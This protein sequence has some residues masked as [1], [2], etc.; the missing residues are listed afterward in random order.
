MPLLQTVKQNS[1]AMTSGSSP[2]AAQTG[3][4][5]TGGDQTQQT[6]QL[7][8]VAQTGKDL[9]PGIGGQAKLS[10]LGERLANVNTLMSASALQ[11]AG[12]MQSEAQQQQ[13][14]AQQQQTQGQMRQLSQEHLDQVES[15]NNQLSGIMQNKADEIQRMVLSDDKSKV[16]QV[17]LML[18]L[19]NDKYMDQ[20]SAAATRARL[21]NQASFQ[22]A[23]N[24]SVFAQETQL[25]GSSLEF[26]NYLQADRRAATD[27][28]ANMDIDFALQ[29]A[30]ADN[31]AAAAT[32]MWS[33]VGGIATGIGELAN[34]KSKPKP[35]D[36]P[37][38][39]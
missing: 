2:L 27:Q 10:A 36:Q 28:L 6:A 7:M 22:I 26:R 13:A 5:A 33:G 35:P 17:G 4:Q 3:M 12:S 25:L 38:G 18:R 1:A 19:G 39:E 23:L 11:Q 15:F 29:I 16:E 34:P 8:G 24:T 32:T 14:E 20:L 30:T 31:R 21:D 9:G 37:D